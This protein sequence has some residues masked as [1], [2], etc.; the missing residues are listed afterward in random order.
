MKLPEGYY[1][2]GITGDIK[3]SGKKDIGLIISEQPCTYAGVFTQNSARAYCVDDNSALLKNKNKIKALLVNSGNANACT[4]NQ[5]IQAVCEIKEKLAQELNTPADSILTASTGATTIHLPV[6]KITNNLSILKD[7]LSK[8]AKSFAEAILTTDTSIKYHELKLGNNSN[9]LGIAKGSGMIHP[10]MATM[11]GF[12]LIDAEVSQDLLQKALGK[13][14]KKS[15]NQISVD[16]D[17]STNDMVLVLANGQSGEKITKDNIQELE[18]KLEIICISLAKQ[19][20]ADGEGATKSIE[21]KLSG[22]KSQELL[23]K[24]ARGVIAS[25]LVKTAIFGNDPNW[26]RIVV[27]A[28]QYAEFNLEETSLSILG[29]TVFSQGVPVD[30]NNQELSDK[31]KASEYITLDLTLSEKEEYKNNIAYAW[32]CDL[33][34]DYVKINAEYTT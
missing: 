31:M 19:I 26:G 16:G 28:G 2:S 34:Y 11:L 27:S 33:S 5:G 6:E 32:G 10:D 25:S 7:K 24:T 12:V 29:Q 20:V 23:E 15:F 8:N 14:I 9:I 22:L 1:A 21:L 3:P 30:Y 4:G 13:A 18:E 17:T